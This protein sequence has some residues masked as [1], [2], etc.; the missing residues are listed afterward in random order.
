[1]KRAEIALRKELAIAHLRIARTEMALARVQKPDSLVVV[2]SAVDLARSV[3][4]QRRFGP[5]SRYARIALG[6]AHVVLGAY[7]PPALPRR[8]DA[9]QLIPNP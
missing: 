4:A 1:M 5:W 8:S 7:R 3:L 6:V 9:V 2:S